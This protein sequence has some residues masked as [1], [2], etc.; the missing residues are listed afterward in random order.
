MH[1]GPD[2]CYSWPRVDKPRKCD[3][4]AEGSNVLV[5]LRAV[6][7]KSTEESNQAMMAVMGISE[8]SNLD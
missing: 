8:T 7:R 5:K 2:G 6:G 3:G 1:S 4:V